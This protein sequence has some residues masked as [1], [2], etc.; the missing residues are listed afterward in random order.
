MFGGSIG[1]PIKKDKAFLFASYQGARRREGQNPG[2]LTVLSPAERTGD[3]SELGFQL[4]DPATSGPFMCGANACNQVPVDS[5]MQN[6]INKYLPLPN[7]PNNGFVED[8]V[9]SLQEDQFIFRFDYNPSSKD[10]LSAFYIFDDQPQN[11]PF[12]VLKGASTGGDV[13]L[14]SG[15]N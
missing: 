11:F 15:F 4:T 8:P 5:V 9:A 13:P 3:F 14:G 6:Y 2:I 10:I 12:E 1:V 7:A